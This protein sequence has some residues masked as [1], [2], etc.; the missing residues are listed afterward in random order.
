M[1]IDHIGLFLLHNNFVMRFVGKIAFPLFAYQLVDS[2]FYTSNRNKFKVRLFIFGLIS[3]IPIG[4]LIDFKYLNVFFTLLICLFVMDGFEKLSNIFGNKSLL[5]ELAIILS[6]FIST[7]FF[8]IPLDWSSYG[9]LIVSI[10]Y[11]YKKG[12]FNKFILIL[13]FV[14]MAII[15]SLIQSTWMYLGILLSLIF[16]FVNFNNLQFKI[17]LP[18]WFGY[19]FYPIHLLIIFLISYLN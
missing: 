1:A 7:A 19:W 15:F 6:L 18:K 5:P 11:W 13:S 17:K 2:Y 10:F 16:I 14:F 4:L 8:D 9:I 12:Y 3:Q